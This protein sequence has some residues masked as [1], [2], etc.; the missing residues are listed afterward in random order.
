M[1]LLKGAPQIWGSWNPITEI[2]LPNKLLNKVKNKIIQLV[3][4]PG[5]TRKVLHEIPFL[6]FAKYILPEGES[7]TV[8]CEQTANMLASQPT[9]VRHKSTLRFLLYS[10]FLVNGPHSPDLTLT[11]EQIN[12]L[13][14]SIGENWFYCKF[15]GFKCWRDQAFMR[16]FTQQ[17]SLNAAGK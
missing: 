17:Q 12:F 11:G 1:T 13:C 15:T 9:K 10:L 5:H 8:A 4:R 2:I 16:I 14:Y 7:T 3:L 6:V